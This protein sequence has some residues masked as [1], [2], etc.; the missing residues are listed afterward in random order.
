[1]EKVIARILLTGDRSSSGKTTVSTGLMAA[2]TTLGYKV[3]PFKVGLDYIDPSYHS[4][5]TGRPS[6]NLDGHLMDRETVLEIFHHACQGADIAII[7]G[8]RGLYEGLESLSDTGSTAQIAKILKC[9]VVMVLDARSIT[10]SCAAILQGYQDFDR[11]IQ[12]EGVILNNLGGR[13]HQEKAVSA[14]EAYTGIPVLGCIHRDSS[15]KI[16]MRHLGLVP[17]LEGR[18]KT[19]DF[20][21][22]IRYI[23]EKIQENL[24]LEKL[25]EISK[26]APPLEPPPPRLYREP[27]VRKKTKIGVALDEAFNFYYA[28]NLDLLRLQGAELVFFSPIHD[29][30]IPDGISGL[31][32]GG[33]YPE[34]FVKELEANHRMREEIWE[35]A[36]GG[37]PIYGECGGLMYLTEEIITTDT[38][39]DARMPSGTF[40]MTGVLPG[41]TIMGK[42]RVV[43]YN[44]GEFTQD[45]VIGRTGDSFTGHEFHHS[46][47]VELPPD[48][49]FAVKLKR[50]S[51]IK[52]KM[53][54]ITR[55][56][57]LA[58]YAHIHAA[59]YKKFTVRFLEACRKT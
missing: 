32:L 47:I 11:E 22:R 50:G 12:I 45:T 6:R 54:G 34:L 24:D 33:G 35:A 16:G 52:D 42:T 13:R 37:L 39:Q 44:Q 18:R 2:L 29:Q 41:K 23:Q 9:P 20:Q 58:M 36:I 48:T 30:G 43:S 3:Q 40:K 10:R 17:A 4:Q 28:D 55:H 7:E 59:S 14:I 49:R 53:D 5:V 38:F 8:V 46:E 31:Y 56:N 15:M 51:G 25:L 57:T 27:E 21:D 1:M 19:E 26:K